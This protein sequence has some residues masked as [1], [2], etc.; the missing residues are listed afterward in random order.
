M[1]YRSALFAAALALD[2]AGSHISDHFVQS[3]LRSGKGATTSPCDW[4]RQLS[5]AVG[6]RHVQAARRLGHARVA[7]S[8]RSPIRAAQWERA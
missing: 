8:C 1:P 3:D 2:R 4:S 7:A 6:R 5:L